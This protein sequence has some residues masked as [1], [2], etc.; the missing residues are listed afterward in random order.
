MRRYVGI[1]KMCSNVGVVHVKILPWLSPGALRK[2]MEILVR[3]T[4]AL[5]T[6]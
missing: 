6:I 1:E 3:I 2:V 4:S 5:A